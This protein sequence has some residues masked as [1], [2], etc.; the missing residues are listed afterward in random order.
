MAIGGVA[1]AYHLIALGPCGTS[2]TDPFREVFNHA[3]QLHAVFLHELVVGGEHVGNLGAFV[4]HGFLAGADQSVALLL[5]QA[6]EPAFSDDEVAAVHGVVDHGGVLLRFVELQGHHI[7]EAAFLTV[8]HALLERVE[9]F[10]KGNGGGLKAESLERGHHEGVLRR[11]DLD[12][13]GVG[14]LADRVLGAGGQL[15]VADVE[16]A[17]QAAAAFLDGPFV[18]LIPHG[19]HEGAEF[20]QRVEHVRHVH[21]AAGRRERGIVVGGEVGDVDGAELDA[22]HGFLFVA[23]LHT[24]EELEVKGVVRILLGQFDEFVIEDVSVVLRVRVHGGRHDHR[25]LRG[26]FRL[27]ERKADHGCAQQAGNKQ[28]LHVISP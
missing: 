23:K 5:G 2:E 24:R 25:G 27:T 22:A 17:Q 15:A 3:E 18:V 11:A 19:V 6:L 16:D 7:V 28:F 10:G 14:E 13:L 20:F 21:P 8:H 26:G 12:A 9:G 4:Q 1:I